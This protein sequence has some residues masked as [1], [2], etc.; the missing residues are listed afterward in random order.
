MNLHAEDTVLKPVKPL[1][2]LA[3]L[4]VINTSCKNDSHTTINEPKHFELAFRAVNGQTELACG[5]PLAGLGTQSTTA[6]LLDFRFYVHG[7]AFI[8][9]DGTH[10]PAALD[11]ND[12]QGQDVALLDFQDKSDNCSGDV[13][14]THKSVTGTIP[15]QD[16]YVGLA[17][18]LGVPPALN[19]MDP[20]RAAAPFNS[21]EMFWS[22]QSGYKAL[23]LDLSP[24]GGITRPSDPNFLGTNY[25]FHLGSTDCSGDPV[26]GEAVT[27]ARTNQPEVVLNGFRFDASQVQID[28]AK[29]LD[30]QDL[31]VDVADAPG[32]MSDLTDT[33]CQ[34]YF[35]QLG[36]DLT[37]GAVLP[38]AT[39][40]VFS[41]RE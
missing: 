17:F 15:A 20:S 1:L 36:L 22:W 27:C 40:T 28:I 26:K 34:G 29:L 8:R 14:P 11:T 12:F 2:G 19:H 23:R 21:T 35:R 24:E 31:N 7:L 18:T 13:K 32:C 10:V 25:F 4:L 39:Q 30:G 5:T 41:L 16:D 38:S 37:S 6:Q 9:A 33:E 3:F